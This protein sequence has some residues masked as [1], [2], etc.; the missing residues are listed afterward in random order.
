MK[1]K[2][3]SD[4]VNHNIRFSEILVIDHNGNQLGILS[5]HDAL[6]AASQQ[7]LDLLIVSPN[8]KIPVAKILDYGRY[9]YDQKK[10]EREAK[11]NQHIMKIKEVRITANIGEHD[12]TVMVVRAKK[13]LLQGN[14]VKVSLKFRGREVKYKDT[15]LATLEHFADLTKD[16]GYI[17]IPAKLTGQYYDMYLKP[18]K[19]DK[20]KEKNDAKDED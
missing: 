13:F 15:G 6:K 3:V 16:E 1:N 9:K 18:N 14:Q 11:K 8:T 19:K 20:I 10:K 17:D 2:P 4:L 7:G 12:L 5:R